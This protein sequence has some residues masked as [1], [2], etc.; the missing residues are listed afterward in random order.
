M[1]TINKVPVTFEKVELITENLQEGVIYVSDEYKCAVHLCLCGCG[2]ET[3]MPLTD[4]EWK[5]EIIDGKISFSP[6]IGNFRFACK[7]HYIITNGVANF[8]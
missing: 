1:K 4:N 5:Y 8:V 3:V 6:S 2:Q 7:S